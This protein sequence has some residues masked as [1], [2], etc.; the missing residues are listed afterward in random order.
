MD[1]ATWAVSPQ[2]DANLFIFPSLFYFSIPPLL[3]RRRW[4]SLSLQTSL[5]SRQSILICRKQNQ[6][7]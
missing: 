4:A 2:P 6:I 1:I 3:S 7:E 5:S